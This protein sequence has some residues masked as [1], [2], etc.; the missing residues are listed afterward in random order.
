MLRDKYLKYI[1]T[2][3]SLL[4]EGREV[5]GGGISTMPYWGDG[6]YSPYLTD[7]ELERVYPWIL[8]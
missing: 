5:W 2:F 7:E 4:V 8:R 6:Y 3:G 1:G